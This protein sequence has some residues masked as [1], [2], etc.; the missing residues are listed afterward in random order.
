MSIV[1]RF[2]QTVN[3]G[4][5]LKY[6]IL[7]VF[8]IGCII[9]MIPELVA[10]PHPIGFDTINYYIPAVAYLDKLW[11]IISGQF[12]VYVY[13]LHLVN[14]STGLSP[15]HT[16]LALAVTMFGIFTVSVFL[17]G[18]SILRLTAIESIFLSVFVIIQIAVLRT[19]WD[20]HR[21]MLALSSLLLTSVLLAKG[22]RATT[23]LPIIG[24][25]MVLSAVTVS[26]DGMIGS[27]FLLSLI[28]YSFITKKKIVILC[29]IVALALFPAAI[30]SEFNIFHIFL[31]INWTKHD[32]TISNDSKYYIES[33]RSYDPT[34]LL[35]FFAVMSGLLIPTGVIGF[36]K[37]F[38][39]DKHKSLLLILPLLISFILSFSWI[40]FP[41][42]TTLVA[43]RWIVVEAIFLS[44]FSG[45]GI[46]CIIKGMKSTPSKKIMVSSSILGVFLIIGIGYATAPVN[47]PFILFDIMNP[48]IRNLA[49]ATMQPD[50]GFNDGLFSVISWI[51]DNTEQNSTITGQKGWRG[52]MQLK[53]EDRREWQDFGLFQ[54]T[55]EMFAYGLDLYTKNH[56]NTYVLTTYKNFL[57]DTSSKLQFRNVFSDNG[58]QVFKILT[59]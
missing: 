16:V 50:K 47:N 28:I 19:S 46:I 24:I 18:K 6:S 10:Y 26:S 25:A 57:N 29:T 27:L 34:N 23:S 43:H 22:H 9:R 21:D 15:Y 20:L 45:Y 54:D 40:L 39:N 30:L 44:I 49:P 48:D 52:F 42:N 11:P 33:N 14:L 38:L 4:F 59:K 37:S 35:I 53:L 58:F 2:Y 55:S 56:K 36:Y 17:V 8:S 1:N 41:Q 51:N 32:A 3:N 31:D 12:P 5:T 7:L 13:L